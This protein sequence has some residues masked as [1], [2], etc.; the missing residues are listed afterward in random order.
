MKV[1]IVCNEEVTKF[2]N[3][4]LKIDEDKIEKDV[5]N[6]IVVDVGTKASSSIDLEEHV[7]DNIEISLNSLEYLKDRAIISPKKKDVNAINYYYWIKF[8]M[9]QKNITELI[10]LLIIMMQ[11]AYL[12]SS[13]IYST[14]RAYHHINYASGLAAQSFFW[15]NLQTP[16][17][18][19]YITF[20]SYNW[21]K[22]IECQ[23]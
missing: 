1:L 9:K 17:F 2:P 20:K 19:C 13:W 14:F 12:F 8:L 22:V 3:R 11:V 7:F 15:G 5:N 4:L 6:S 21:S 16:K 18:G 23:I 10:E